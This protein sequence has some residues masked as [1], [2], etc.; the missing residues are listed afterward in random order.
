MQMIDKPMRPEISYSFRL[1][2][3]VVVWVVFCIA[4]MSVVVLHT[5]HFNQADIT[6]FS[7]FTLI[8][9]FIISIIV[10]SRT[11]G[12]SPLA[13]SEAR[14]MTTNIKNGAL[15]PGIEPGHVSE[16]FH[17]FCRYSRKCFQFSIISTL[18]FTLV[19]LIWR[20]VH[21][22]NPL[23]LL[24]IVIIG[25]IVTTLASG[26]SIFLPQLQFFPI[27]K[28][29]RDFLST[30]GR[31][32]IESSFQSIRI[33]FLFII[34]FLLDALALFF[35]AG[36]APEM[37]G[38][39]IF[40]TG[41]FMIV[42]VTLLLLMYLEKAFKDFFSLTKIDI[43]DE[44]PIFSTGSLDKEFI[45]LTKFLNEISIQLY[46]FKEKTKSSEREMV[47]RMEELERFFDLTIEREERMIE[48]KKENAR[49]KQKLE[50][51]QENNN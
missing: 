33:K 20:A 35:L 8:Y 45:N 38:F 6:N 26:F 34:I 12:V 21:P 43:G 42:F 31:C 2:V 48:L 5:C 32:P 36:Y 46:F 30:K 19:T 50:T 17:S 51:I 49:L 47:K 18:L 29:C 13:L 9:I 1:A 10:F 40:F 11:S 25:G 14:V 22:G 15:I 24:M 37:I 23:D 7:L 4:F 39:N 28:Q 27:A 3:P 16:T 44:L 41:I